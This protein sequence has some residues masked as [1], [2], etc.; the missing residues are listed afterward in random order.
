MKTRLHA[1]AGSIAL[2]TISGFWL[3]TA[4]SE[5]FLSDAAIATVKT[6]VLFGMAVLIPALATT[7]VAGAALG[8]GTKLAQVKAKTR[9]MKLITLNG[10]AILLPSAVFLA[11]KAQT[12]AFDGVFYT[13]QLLELCAGATNITLLSLN[14]RDGIALSR[15][16]KA[17][18]VR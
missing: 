1:A 5:I 8:K 2:L 9:R 16:R 13:V 17:V 12:G 18:M 14:M 10:V 15:R 7:G 6:A 11:M 3:S 4:I